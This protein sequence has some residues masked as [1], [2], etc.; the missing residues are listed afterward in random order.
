[1]VM[2]SHKARSGASRPGNLHPPPRLSGFAHPDRSA[3]RIGMLGIRGEPQVRM[4]Q[5]RAAR[6]CECKNACPLL[7][8]FWELVA[9]VLKER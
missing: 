5:L 4:R 8:D 9:S 7:A 6:A 1:M 2:M 3:V